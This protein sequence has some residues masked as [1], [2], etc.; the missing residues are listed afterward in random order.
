MNLAS[1]VES[2]VLHSGHRDERHAVVTVNEFGAG[3]YFGLAAVAVAGLP[4][5]A[6]Y[7]IDV[8]GFAVAQHLEAH[9]P[10]RRGM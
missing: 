9:R 8:L 3:R 4:I 10:S 2:V 6:F 1:R 7:A 5:P